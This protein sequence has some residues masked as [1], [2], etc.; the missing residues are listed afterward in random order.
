MLTTGE[1][2]KIKGVCERLK[3][4]GHYTGVSSH[5]K[6]SIVWMAFLGNTGKGM[7]LSFASHGT[8]ADHK[9]H[10]LLFFTH[11]QV[12]L[13]WVKVAQT[14]LLLQWG[15]LLFTHSLISTLNGSKL[16]ALQ[17]KSITF[18]LQLQD[19]LTQMFTI[20]MRYFLTFNTELK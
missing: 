17:I 16:T 4:F 9:W 18:I 3:E 5:N 10:S 2:K 15:E 13:T 20:I 14:P 6:P 11:C 7:P 1:K 8:E 19:I 12:C